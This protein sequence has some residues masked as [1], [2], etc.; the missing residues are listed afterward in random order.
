M[1]EHITWMEPTRTQFARSMCLLSLGLTALSAL[2][3]G[4]NRGHPNPFPFSYWLPNIVTAV[5]FS[6]VGMLIATHRLE[7]IIGWM[8]CWMGLASAI[9]ALGG[10]YA[11]HALIIAPGSLP[12]GAGAAWLANLSLDI[13]WATAFTLLLLLFPTGRVLSRRWRPLIWLAIIDIIATLVVAAICPG[14]FDDP[15]HFASNP[16]GITHPDGVANALQLSLS[17]LGS[18]PLLMGTVSI[19]SLVLRFRR[20]HGVER[21]QIKWFVFSVATFITLYTA[22]YAVYQPIFGT[23]AWEDVA[24]AVIIVVFLCIGVPSSVGIAILRYRLYEIDR[25]INRTLVYGA[26]T[27]ALALVYLSLVIGLGG[28]VRTLTGASSNLVIAASTLAVAGLF[29]PFR[30]RIQTMVDHRFYRHK[31]DATRTL[32]TFSARLRDEIDLDALLAELDAVVRETMQPAH[33]SLWM[34]GFSRGFEPQSEKWM[35]R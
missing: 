22:L 10:Q 23:A 2:F 27:A 12:G 1:D 25:I 18:I 11:A 13:V 34:R 31:Y 14:P 26:L 33:T 29:Q 21:E 28:L 30:S 4:L 7:N 5:L 6:I 35:A 19:L 24:G 32:E 16:F 17:V 20:S 3:Y 8:L 15:L 9:V